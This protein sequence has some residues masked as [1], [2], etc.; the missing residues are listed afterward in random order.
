MP[1]KAVVQACHLL[2]KTAPSAVAIVLVPTDVGSTSSMRA[3]R[4]LLVKPR[5]GLL[6]LIFYWALMDM[7]FFQS[8][9]T[10][11]VTQNRKKRRSYV[12]F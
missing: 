6:C 11:N 1:R 8:E 5:V 12:G 3:I 4:A 9:R 2:V 10:L 7:S